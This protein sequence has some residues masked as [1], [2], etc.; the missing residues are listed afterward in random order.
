MSNFAATMWFMTLDMASG[1]WAVPMTA[2]AQL[3][4]AFICPL[5][6][7]QWK[8][9]PFGLKNAPLIYQQLLDNCLWGF[10]RLPPE[11]ERLV[12]PEMGPVLSRSSYIDDIIY[13]APSWD[14]LC[15][16]LNA[17]LYRLRYWNISVSLP[18]SEFGVKKCK[19]LGHDIS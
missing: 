13:G 17:L 16:T 4:S 9:M 7:F 19:Y 8:R 1:F 12:D 18:K 10:V 2:R 3:I 11:E 5:G 14:D 15:K 6:H